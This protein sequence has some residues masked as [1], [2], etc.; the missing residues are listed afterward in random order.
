MTK[1][2]GLVGVVAGATAANMLATGATGLLTTVL[3]VVAL[4]G[5]GACLV[6][7]VRA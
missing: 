2:S 5:L 1:I 6:G 4:L 3:M 7:A